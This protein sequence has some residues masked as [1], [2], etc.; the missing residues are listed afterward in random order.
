MAAEVL[1]GGR[2]H[3]VV[4][5]LASENPA[6]AGV[7]DELGNRILDLPNVGVRDTIP[8]YDASF[9]GRVAFATFITPSYRGR[10]NRRL[11]D[12]SSLVLQVK[13]VN[14]QEFPWL[15]PDPKIVDLD[16]GFYFMRVRDVED[17]DRAMRVIQASY[18]AQ[19]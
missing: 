11:V 17:V 16:K 1:T 15:V 13:F 18:Q 19:R 3:A 12:S 9:V 5:R 7:I 10:W 2:A 4:A 8:T 14:E 6:Q